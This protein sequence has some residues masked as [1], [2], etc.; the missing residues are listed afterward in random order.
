MLKKMTPS[1]D[2][3]GTVHS[4][5]DQMGSYSDASGVQVRREVRLVDGALM[6]EGQTARKA[7]LS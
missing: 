7:G 2:S 5:V 6:W 3:S 4:L 1:W